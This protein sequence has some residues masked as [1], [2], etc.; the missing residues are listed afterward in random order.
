MCFDELTWKLTWKRPPEEVREVQTLAYT[1]ILSKNC[2][3]T[4]LT[5][6]FFYSQ[7][8]LFIFLNTF[9]FK[10]NFKFLFSS[11]NNNV[12]LLELLFLSYSQNIRYTLSPFSDRS[13]YTFNLSRWEFS[14]PPRFPDPKKR[15]CFV[16]KIYILSDRI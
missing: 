9:F 14:P 8:C 1:R 13:R 12:I 3:F 10:L 4:V 11:N 2:K 6:F 15:N 5:N 7:T 16:T